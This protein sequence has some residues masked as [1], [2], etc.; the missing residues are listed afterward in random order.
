M[1][2]FPGETDEEFEKSLRL[3][4]HIGFDAAFTFAYSPRPG[5]AAA[6]RQDE[7][8]REVSLA[9]LRQLITVQN[10]ITVERNQA[11]VGEEAEVLLD[12]PAPRGEGLLAGR[13][14]NN[15]QVILQGD[16]GLQGS[17]VRVRLTEAHLWG[18]RAALVDH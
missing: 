12:G 13:A 16:R 3:Y 14:R 15:K 10:R 17:L 8:P 1:V 2:G 7:V 9:R 4:E 11:G 18:F 5:T 6:Q